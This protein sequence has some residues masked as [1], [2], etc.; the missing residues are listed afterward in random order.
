MPNTTDWTDITVPTT[1]WSDTTPNTADWELPGLVDAI[2][3]DDAD[4][5]YD[6]EDTF[7]DGYDFDHI[8]PEGAYYTDWTDVT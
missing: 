5:T 8:T 7:Y 2:T 3:Y 6:D 1:D 4:T